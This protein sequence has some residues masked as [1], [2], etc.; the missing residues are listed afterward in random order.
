ML[1]RI[2]LAAIGGLLAI[3]SRVSASFRQAVT[4]DLVVEITTDDGVA[5]HYAFR[6]RLVS[7][8]PGKAAGADCSLRFATASQGCARFVSR[9]TVSHLV[10]GMQAGTVSIRG[11]A[12]HLLWFADLTQR[13]AP[14]A[15]KVRWGTPPH[16][17]VA[18]STTIG[19]GQAHHPRAGC[20]GARS[21][22]GR[23]RP[24][25]RES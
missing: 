17:Y 11:N 18:P 15:E 6:D 20:R 25:S 19:R 8:H 5:H 2:V 21:D 9:H 22:V 16:A 10:A 3:A 14:L 24:Q 12:F 13:V 7:S 23:S 4:R 1:L